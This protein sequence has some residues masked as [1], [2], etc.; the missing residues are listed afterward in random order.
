MIQEEVGQI[1][2][3]V[4]RQELRGQNNR[5]ANYQNTRGRQSFQGQPFVIIAIDRVTSSQRVDIEWGKCKVKHQVVGTPESQILID[6]HEQTRTGEVQIIRLAHK[7]SS[8]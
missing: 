1:V 3:Q 4:I 6:P 7:I 2:S 5:H 8:I